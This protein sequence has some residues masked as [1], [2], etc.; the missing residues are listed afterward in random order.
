MGVDTK[1]ILRK[2]TTIEQIEKPFLTIPDYKL[3]TKKYHCESNDKWTTVNSDIQ[4]Y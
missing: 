3:N 4:H 1:A 2:G